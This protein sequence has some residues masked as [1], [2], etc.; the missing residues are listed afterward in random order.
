[1][2]IQDKKQDILKAASS[3]FARYGYEKTTLD[4]IGKL[5]SLNKASLYYYYKNKESIYTEVIFTEANEV[6]CSVFGE[7]EKVEG[8]KE[9]VITYLTEKL[10]YIKN[11]MNL[12]QLS[13]DS[14]QKIAPLF[15]EMN[16]KIMEKEIANLSEILKGCIKNDEIIP[17]DTYKVAR[18]IIT[19]SEAIRTRIDCRLSTDEAYIEVL[20]EIKFTVSLILDGLKKKS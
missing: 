12:K 7:V 17:C 20:D 5:V 14:V 15:C 2:D 19:V 4:D 16:N 3:C 9:K 8:Y 18:G 13:I 1:M 11:S 10:N 6:L